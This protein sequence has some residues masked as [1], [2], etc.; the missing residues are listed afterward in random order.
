MDLALVL[1]DNVKNQI[2][3]TGCHEGNYSMT[4]MLAGARLE[5]A[6]GVR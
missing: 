5:E 4:S 2:G 1:Q 6:R 3:E